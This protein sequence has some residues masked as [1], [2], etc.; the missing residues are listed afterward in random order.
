MKERPLNLK[1]HEVLAFLSGKKTQIRVALTPQ[2]ADAWMLGVRRFD[3]TEEFGPTFTSAAHAW[4]NYYA[5]RL[6][7]DTKDWF[8]RKRFWVRHPDN[9][10][11]IVCPL[12]EPGD[13]LWGREK[14]GL[15]QVYHNMRPPEKKHVCIAYAA[16]P[17]EKCRGRI[18]PEPPG[19][20]WD[21]P[22]W[23]SHQGGIGL[24]TMYLGATQM[25]RW[26]SRFLFKITNVRVEKLHDLTEEDARADGVI[27][28]GTQM[29]YR[30]YLW[31][32]DED[33]P[34]K[35][36][37]RWE[38]QYSEYTTAVGSFSS[39]WER[40]HGVGAWDKNPWV[41]AVTLEGL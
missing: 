31:H 1:S 32:G 7:P 10:S 3:P 34:R 38:Y 37:E 27:G 14:F 12:G 21:R 5:R 24:Q 16:T 41:W 29:G 26:A 33:A 2:P 4:R 11:E 28:P 17:T 19:L 39:L 9:M 23:R 8:Y 6:N 25:P 22:G 35:A 18:V 20:N 13:L 36:V 30:N 40:T 15:E